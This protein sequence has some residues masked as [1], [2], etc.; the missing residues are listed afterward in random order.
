VFDLGPSIRALLAN[1]RPSASP[2]PPAV[3]PSCG[4]EHDG[5]YEDEWLGPFEE[6]HRVHACPCGAL[7]L[8]EHWY[9]PLVVAARLAP[10][11]KRPG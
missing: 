7:R 4:A 2:A 10:A 9:G 6:G 11:P 5:R 1:R 3:C 8:D